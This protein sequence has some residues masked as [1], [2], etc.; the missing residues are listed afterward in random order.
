MIIERNEMEQYFQ[1]IAEQSK[2]YSIDGQVNYAF[3]AGTLQSML[4][5][6]MGSD[7]SKDV[8]ATIIKKTIK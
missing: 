7:L 6:A 2:E 3:I 4:T 8:V 1:A 5:S